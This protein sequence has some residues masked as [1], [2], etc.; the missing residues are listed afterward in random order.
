MNRHLHQ[1]LMLLDPERHASQQLTEHDELLLATIMDQAQPE[2]TRSRR[3][4]ARRIAIVG[5]AA[6]SV[7]ALGLTRIDLGG[8]PVGSSPAAAAVLE[9]AADAAL[10]E[11]PL[12]VKPGQYLLL[13]RIEEHWAAIDDES[14]NGPS[15]VRIGS[16]GL[17]VAFQ[18]RQTWQRWIPYDTSAEWIVRE[19]EEPLRNVSRESARFNE[20][21]GPE[22]YHQPSWSNRD[23][24]STYIA[25]YDPA[26]YAS[27]PRDPDKLLAQLKK[28]IGAGDDTSPEH[29]FMEVYS[30]VLRNGLAPP[31]IRSALFTA[32]SRQP[33]MELVDGVANLDGRRGVALKF[34]GSNWQ[35][36][37]DRDTGEFIGERA[38]DPDFPD[39]PG[40]D[41][42]HTTY[43]TTVRAEVVDSA[44]D[45]D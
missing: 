20:E 13:T 1:S 3:P 38:T 34:T 18:S 6:A 24:T 31:D 29:L 36:L 27:L 10:A 15:S 43:L 30:E 45:P 5:L 22:V 11:P 41:D 12:I 33:G 44:P 7:V 17:P 35:M 9:R 23:G 19:S 37:F 40:I 16:D 26:W 2:L 21:R 25:T 39:V 32:L 28:D 4:Y 14:M 8:R 42:A